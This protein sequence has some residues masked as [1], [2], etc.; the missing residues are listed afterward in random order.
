ML[1]EDEST[2]DEREFQN[3]VNKLPGD[4]ILL[5]NENFVGQSLF[6][7]Y[8]N[9]SRIAHRLHRAMPQATVILFLRNQADIL[10]S[11]YE[12]SLQDKE[13]ASLLDFIR[14]ALPEYSIETY[15]Q[16][17]AVDLFDYA[18]FDSYHSGEKASLYCYSSLIELYKNLFPKVEIFLFEDFVHQPETVLRRLFELLGET[19]SEQFIQEIISAPA[20][21]TGVNQKQASQLRRL[22]RWYP[23]LWHSRAGRA[24][25]VRAKRQIL[26]QKRKGSPIHWTDEQVEKLRAIFEDDNRMLNEK[27]P[28]IGLSRYPKKYFLD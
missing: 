10:R 12:I 5:S 18:P 17:P 27:Y 24:L 9:R 15:K 2:F 28:E 14:F 11:L 26:R 22:N 3:E 25:Y 1:F 8:G 23:V 19:S 21:N 16:H 4:R 6:L 13:T 7:N 20:A